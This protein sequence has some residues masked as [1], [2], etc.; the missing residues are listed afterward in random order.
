M[1]YKSDHIKVLKVLGSNLPKRPSMKTSDIVAKGFKGADDGD[2]RVRNAYR[3]CR[4]SGHIA[5]GERGEYQMTQSGAAW[6]TKAEKEGFKTPEKAAKK[7]SKPAKK[8]PKVAAKKAAPKAAKKV[9][10]KTAKPAVK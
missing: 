6:F 4:K 2:R 3:M 7:V 5:I 10:P 9:A 8:L 1:P